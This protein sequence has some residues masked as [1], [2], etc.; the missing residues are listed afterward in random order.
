MSSCS[1]QVSGTGLASGA[2]ERLRI[3]SNGNVGRDQHAE[4]QLEVAGNLWIE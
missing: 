2:V 3:L 1:R 4:V